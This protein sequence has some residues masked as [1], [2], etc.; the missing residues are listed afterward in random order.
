MCP[1]IHVAQMSLMVVCLT[2]E[3]SVIRDA[4]RHPLQPFSTFFLQNKAMWSLRVRLRST[5]NKLT[6]M[7]IQSWMNLKTEL[8]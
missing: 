3:N 1:F 2:D 8:K 4:D 7:K 5:S 6:E